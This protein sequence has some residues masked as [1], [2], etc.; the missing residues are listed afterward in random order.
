MG[1]LVGSKRAA[2][3]PAGNSLLAKV[4]VG[5][6]VPPLGKLW[7]TAFGDIAECRPECNPSHFSP[8]AG[9]VKMPSPVP[10]AHQT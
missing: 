4:V 6:Q 5:D 2:R 10:F 9:A 3:G 8:V 7:Q 1:L